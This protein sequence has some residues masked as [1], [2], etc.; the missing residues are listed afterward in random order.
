MKA[1]AILEASLASLRSAASPADAAN[2]FQLSG[3]SFVRVLDSTQKG[4][5]APNSRLVLR[6]RSHP[7]LFKEPK[8]S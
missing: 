2:T 4:G 5:G 6:I 3:K 7:L 8:V 1:V